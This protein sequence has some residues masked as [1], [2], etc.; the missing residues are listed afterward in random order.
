MTNFNYPVGYKPEGS[1]IEEVAFHDYMLENTFVC[2]GQ[3]DPERSFLGKLQNITGQDPYEFN[4]ALDGARL[5]IKE[6]GGPEKVM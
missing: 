2:L 6:A 1:F 3:Q 5:V 4:A